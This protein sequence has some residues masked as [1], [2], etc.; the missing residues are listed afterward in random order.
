MSALT[1]FLL[2]IPLLNNLGPFTITSLAE[3]SKTVKYKK[4]ET[5]LE[6]GNEC[7]SLYIVASGKLEFYKKFDEDEIIIIQALNTGDV[8]G[9]DYLFSGLPV[10]GYLQAGSNSVVVTIDRGTID[11]ILKDNT[12]FFR[13]YIQTLNKK[14]AA[15]SDSIFTL[16]NMLISVD[17]HIPEPYKVRK[18]V[19]QEAANDKPLV[20]I[21]DGV[22]HIEDSNAEDTFYPKE[23]L[24]PL[25]NDKYTTLKPR[26]KYTMIDRTDADSCPYYKVVNPIYYEINTCPHCGYSFNNSTSAP[27]SADVKEAVRKVLNQTYKG[28]D[29]TGVREL[30]DAIKTFELATQCQWRVGAEA[31]SLGRMFLKYGWLYRY[32]KDPAKEKEQMEKALHYLAK[33]YD[34]EEIPDYKEEMNIMFLIGQIHLNLDDKTGALHWFIRIT[35]HPEKKKYPYIVNRSSEIW[36]EIRQELKN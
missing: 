11:T 27:V 9:E 1:N 33:F 12:T 26:H 13:N 6:Q 34:E 2:G 18:L 36:S 29:Y 16:L 22:E 3:E 19:D 20:L 14:D 28:Q 17:L 4:G 24:C 10:D 35:Q 8:F 31:F 21:N 7:N 23:I 32:K 5:I 15:K 30:E 25:C